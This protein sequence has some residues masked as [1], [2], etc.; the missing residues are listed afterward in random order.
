MSEKRISSKNRLTVATRANHRC[1]YCQSWRKFA[2]QS[3]EVEHILPQSLGGLSSL[4]NLAYACGGCNRH[5]YNKIT[6]IEP[7]SGKEIP[8]FHP[9]EQ[10]WKEHFVWNE[11]YTLIIGL[12]PIGRAT[13]EALQ[14]NRPGLVNMRELLRAAGLH[15][16][17]DM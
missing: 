17:S 4:D 7:I 6:A 13:K 2:T 8:L 12:S 14:L 5:K 3:F 9:R 16:P 1:E 10:I 15:P 11:D